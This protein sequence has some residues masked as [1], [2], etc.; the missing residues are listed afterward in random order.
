VGLVIKT[1]W[2]MLLARTCL[3]M[4]LV[5]GVVGSL[6]FVMA[7]MLPGDM[8]T[9]IAAGRYG[10]DLVG[11]AAADAVRLELGLHVPAWQAW[12]QWLLQLCQ[13]QLGQSLV[14]GQS[15][16]QEVGVQLGAT[17]WLSAVSSVMALVVG[18]P[19]GLLAAMSP[20]GLWDRFTLVWAI[21]LRS[22][23]TFL[24]ALALMLLVSVHGGFLP[25]ASDGHADG[26]WLPAATLALALS[27]GLVR[28]VRDALLAFRLSPA[29]LFARG[30]GLSE[31][32][33]LVRHGF[34]H[35]AV[36][37]VAYMGVHVALLVEGAVVVESL[38]A[39]PGAGHA[40]VHAIFA[41]DIPMIQG[42]ALCMGMVF[43]L[44]GAATDALGLAL[45]PRRRRTA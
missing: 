2:A 20:G 4:A 36:T 40:L 19:M 34:R 16:W 6:C 38:F 17:L 7:R 33:V 35:V 27:G 9:R 15:V 1:A 18:V 28:M 37:V 29:W 12:W 39:W 13:G 30:K 3:Q 11:N 44:W 43:V 26:V 32:Q 8:A 14:T 31:H 41:R 5:V 10:Y 42:T 21:A 45:D 23:P 22:V 24:L 25:V